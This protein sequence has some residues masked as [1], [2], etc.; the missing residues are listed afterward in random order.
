MARFEADLSA[1]SRPVGIT[2]NPK[3]ILPQPGVAGPEGFRPTLH[4]PR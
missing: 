4:I 2:P 3:T 1:A